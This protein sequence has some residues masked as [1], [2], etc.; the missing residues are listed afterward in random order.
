MFQAAAQQ[1]AVVKRRVQ[2]YKHKEKKHMM[3]MF[4]KYIEEETEVSAQSYLN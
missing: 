4:S 3:N 1:V 2:E